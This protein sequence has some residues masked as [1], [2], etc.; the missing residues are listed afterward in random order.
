LEERIRVLIVDD[1]DLFR[2]GLA[3][4]FE[5]DAEVTVAGQASTSSEA[6]ELT[7][8]IRPDVVLAKLELPD[9]NGLELARG[10]SR[11]VPGTRIALIARSFSRSTLIEAAKAGVHGYLTKD[12]TLPTLVDAVKRVARGEAFI[13]PGSSAMLIEELAAQSSDRGTI[14]PRS[15]NERAKV[16]EREREVLQLIVQGA[17]N[18]DIARQLL[19]TENTVKVHLRNIL[20]KLHLRNR[21]QAAAFAVSAGLV[22]IDKAEHSG[23]NGEPRNSP[24]DQPATWRNRR[25][26]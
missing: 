25:L 9:M 20:D 14:A 6:L 2:R 8:Q 11:S 4:M 26:G 18:R 12:V 3:I 23:G 5:K 7:R 24:Q 17:T 21:Q 13:S 16:T 15:Q 1:E 19:I 10:I 22:D